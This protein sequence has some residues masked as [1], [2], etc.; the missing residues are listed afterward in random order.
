[1]EVERGAIYGAVAADLH[2]IADLHVA[3]VADLAGPP[4]GVHGVTETIAADGRVRMDL[5][6]LADL[7][8]EADE[9]LRVQ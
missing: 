4:T 7:T 6:V 2:L 1:M 8:T 3:E 5:A 9:H